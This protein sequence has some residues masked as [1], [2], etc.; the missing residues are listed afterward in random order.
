M[1]K[2]L[3]EIA[4]Q[5]GGEI[6][7]DG[8]VEI[9]G[10]AGIEEA[11]SGDLTFVANPRYVKFLEATSASAVIVGKEIQK[12]KIPILRHANPYYAFAKA[13]ALFHKPRKSYPEKIDPTALLGKEIKVGKGVYV[14]PYVI[15]EDKAKLGDK[16]VIL[17]GALSV[18]TQ[19]SEKALLSI[20]T[21]P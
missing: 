16:A 8:S 17:G 11:R 21:L 5:L 7:G 19:K 2:T 3:E 18:K 1:K 12:A 10:V 6:Y 4:S 9:S 14:G 20:P 13:I 15:I